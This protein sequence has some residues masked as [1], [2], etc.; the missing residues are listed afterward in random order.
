MRV[1]PQGRSWPVSL[2]GGLHACFALGL[3]LAVAPMVSCGCERD[4]PCLEWVRLGETYGVELVQHLE[5]GPYPMG[6]S[7]PPCGTHLELDVGDVAP[8]RAAGRSDRS[9]DDQCGL[10]CSYVTMQPMI[11]GVTIL[12]E[13]TEGGAVGSL[14]F[15]M[16]AEVRIG[17]QCTGSYEMSLDVVSE[18][19]LRTSGAHLATDHVL[20][21]EF[22]PSGPGCPLDP[23]ELAERSG[24]CW[25][26]WAVRIRDASGRLVS[27]DLAAPP[28]RDAGD[29]S[30]AAP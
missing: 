13:R 26:T 15:F 2:R 4:R 24:R 3:V 27:R 16:G 11:E 8:I 23:L 14:R 25:D 21:R 6:D 1:G 28:A 20:F 22:I 10:G 17:D 7:V 12:R 5:E 29:A 9:R 19:F 30:D 18:Y